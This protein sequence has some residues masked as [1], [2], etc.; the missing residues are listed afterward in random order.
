[1]KA[2]LSATYVDLRDHR[3]AAVEAIQRAGHEAVTMETFGARPEE[4]TTACLRELEKCNLIVGV[5]AHRYGFIPPGQKTSITEQE[6]EHARRTGRPVFSFLVADDYPWPPK[7]IDSEPGRTQLVEFKERV[8]N[9]VVRDVFTTPDDL[10]F[11]VAAA[12]GR[13]AVRERAGTLGVE[14]KTSLGSAD[15]NAR[16]LVQGRSLSDAP[17]DTRNRVLRLLNE[18]RDTVDT[19]PESTGPESVIDPDAI[20]ALAE[21]LMAQSKWVEAGRELEAYARV[22]PADWEANNLRGVAFANSRKGVETDLE[23]LRAYNEAI[24]F[25]PSGAEPNRWARLFAY[26]G[27]MLKRLGRLEES[28]ADLVIAQRHASQDYEI[29]DIIYNLAGVF[30]MQ[31]KR[32]QLLEA[33]RRLSR[34]RRLLAAIRAHLDDYFEAY[35]NDEEFLQLI[36]AT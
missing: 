19:L 34:K 31:R 14:L 26:R 2:F 28:E 3:R 13:Y 15:L 11:K 36:G 1:M 18:L 29:H 33:V 10:A 25:F 6:Y 21:G 4:P 5:Y 17:E 20:L 22:R 30:A 24:A 7:Y 23:S 32:E 8:C 16:G 12:V 27:A 9:Q 35:R